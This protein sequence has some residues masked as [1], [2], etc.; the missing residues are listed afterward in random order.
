MF[1]FLPC[2]KYISLFIILCNCS[3]RKSLK[4]CEQQLP[5]QLLV[6]EGTSKGIL[7]F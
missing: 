2:Q 4:R 7:K 6:S 3:D 1:H 5:S